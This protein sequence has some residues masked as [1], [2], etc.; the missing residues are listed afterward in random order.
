[1]RTTPPGM[2][3]GGRGAG[4][5]SGCCSASARPSAR[6]PW[7]SGK[8]VPRGRSWFSHSRTRRRQPAGRPVCPRHSPGLPSAHSARVPAA[9]PCTCPRPGPRP[10]A[11]PG[12][13]TQPGTPLPAPGPCLAWGAPCRMAH[14]DT[15]TGSGDG[16]RRRP[17][18]RWPPCPALEVAW[19]LSSRHSQAQGRANWASLGLVSRVK[20][21]PR[22][23]SPPSASPPGRREESSLGCFVTIWPT[24]RDAPQRVPSALHPM[25]TAQASCSPGKPSLHSPSWSPGHPQG[26]PNAPSKPACLPGGF[27]QRLPLTQGERARSFPCPPPHSPGPEPRPPPLPTHSS[28]QEALKCRFRQDP[29][30]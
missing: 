16:H 2:Q 8:P 17:A 19:T 13:H 22:V 5:P 28:L 12:M 20:A 25:A 15:F 3:C 27:S 23:P 6:T 9:C 11:G 14:P 4:S 10:H 30:P 18:P 7:S 21:V 24:P 1:M 29:G 26:L